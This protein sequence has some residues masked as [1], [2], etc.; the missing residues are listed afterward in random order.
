MFTSIRIV[1]LNFRKQPLRG[2][3]KKLVFISF[4][5]I[6]K[7]T[8]FLSS[9]ELIN[10]LNN[11]VIG[12]WWFH[13]DFIINYSSTSPYRTNKKLCLIVTLNEQRPKMVRDALKVLQHFLQDFNSVSDHFQTLYM[14]VNYSFHKEISFTKHSPQI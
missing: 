8:T 10:L 5:K 13:Y 14:R 6:F 12:G 11:L 7:E 3:L 2:I 1:F 9:F 4:I